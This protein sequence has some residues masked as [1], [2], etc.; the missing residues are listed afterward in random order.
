MFCAIRQSS[1]NNK[2]LIVAK[3]T[4]LCTHFIIQLKNNKWLEDFMYK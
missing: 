2:Q 3:K 1:L 4:K